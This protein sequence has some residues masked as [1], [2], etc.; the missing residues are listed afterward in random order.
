VGGVVGGVAALVAVASGI[1]F[2]RRNRRDPAK[3]ELDKNSAYVAQ[4]FRAQLPV[5]ELS[6]PELPQKNHV[7]EVSGD[8]AVYE[9]MGSE[10]Y[11]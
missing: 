5:Q 4:G 10:A 11:R 6:G 9:V 2:W 7:T 8:H 3:T 1:Y